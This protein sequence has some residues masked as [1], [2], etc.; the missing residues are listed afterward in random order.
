[1]K[2]AGSG[3]RLMIYVDESEHHGDLPVYAAIVE[4][5]QQA[6]LAGATVLR[7]LEGFGAHSHLHN[8]HA[9]PV[10]DHAPMVVIVVDT[11][12]RIERFLPELDALVDEALVVRQPV[13]VV[14]YRRDSSGHRKG[15]R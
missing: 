8:Q 3:E 12:E 2:V 10:G 11:E 15:R 1:M 9:L 13:D 14:A 6:G 7:G 4:R 5:A